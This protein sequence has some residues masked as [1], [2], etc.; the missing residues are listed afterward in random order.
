[1]TR[2]HK[3][4]FSSGAAFPCGK[5]PPC[6]SRRRRT[7]AGRLL[8][9]RCAHAG[10]A[11]FVT[12][13]YAEDRQSLC[14]RDVQLWL[15]RLRKRSA[16]LRVFYVGEYG[17]CTERP[18]YHA[19]LFGLP[20]CPGGPFERVSARGYRCLCETCSA[21]RETWRFGNVC[22]SNLTDARAMYIAGYVLKKMTHRLDPRLYGREPEFARMSRKP[23]I[24]AVALSPVISELSKRRRTVPH[25]L[26]YGGRMRPLGRYL[27]RL[28]AKGLCDGSETAVQAVL[29]SADTVS[30]NKKALSVLRAYAWAVDKPVEKVWQE[31]F[32]ISE[33]NL[34]VPVIPVVH[35]LTKAVRNV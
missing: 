6:L 24:G 8:L 18:H 32:E 7:W 11:V 1:M 12:L 35:R 3:P 17:D 10:R 5:C 9:E 25:G 2:C 15:K 19:A 13:T 34:V 26:Q 22:V 27:R 29:G 28:V 30:R 16:P 20:E 33:E 14:I 4:Y 23:G 31:V 21:V